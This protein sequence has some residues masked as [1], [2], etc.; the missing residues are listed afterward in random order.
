MRRN[1]ELSE[2]FDCGLEAVG[3]AVLEKGFAENGV[4]RGEDL[5]DREEMGWIVLQ[6]GNI[7][8]RVCMRMISYVWHT[9][10]WSCGLGGR[11][12]SD[13]CGE[14]GMGDCVQI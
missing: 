10:C 5:K 2:L 4:E 13:V 1:L 3:F 6:L 12:V 14:G 9:C 7:W 11:V 8:R